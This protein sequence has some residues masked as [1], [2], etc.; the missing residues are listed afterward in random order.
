MQNE[1]KRGGE[2][3]SLKIFQIFGKICT[4]FEYI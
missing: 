2:K 1:D 4:I 3:K